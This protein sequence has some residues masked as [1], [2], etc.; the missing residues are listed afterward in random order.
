M[1][2]GTIL[3]WREPQ[4][5]AEESERYVLI[6]DNGDRYIVSEVAL[7]HWPIPP[8]FCYKASDLSEV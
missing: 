3:K 4:S 6:E 1:K 5:I 8:Q 2:K 7:Q